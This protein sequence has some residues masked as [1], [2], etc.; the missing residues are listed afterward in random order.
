MSI[1]GSETCGDQGEGSRSSTSMD[2]AYSTCSRISGVWAMTLLT[3]NRSAPNRWPRRMTSGRSAMFRF[4]A[5]NAMPSRGPAERL[6]RRRSRNAARSSI[7]PGR[8]SHSRTSA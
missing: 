8:A 5:T 4:M 1:R 3:E 7:T 2:P 6:A